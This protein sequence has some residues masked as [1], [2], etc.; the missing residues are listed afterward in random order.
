MAVI[1]SEW[2]EGS[3]II[4]TPATPYNQDSSKYDCPFCRKSAKKHGRRD[5]LT[6]RTDARKA[7][8]IAVFCTP[9]NARG[10]GKKSSSVSVPLAIDC[11]R[12]SDDAPRMVV[13]FANKCENEKIKI[14]SEKYETFKKHLSL[15][16]RILLKHT[17]IV[18]KIFYIHKIDSREKLFAEIKICE[19][20]GDG[21]TE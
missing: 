21:K 16:T 1:G 12:L 18:E 7:L 8:L 10:L 17:Q 3:R 2:F 6:L 19:K 15:K 5:D 13:V 20:F 9:R 4:K 11:V 14:Y